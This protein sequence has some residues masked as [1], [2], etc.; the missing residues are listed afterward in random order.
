MQYAV[1]HRCSAFDF[2]NVD[3]GSIARIT[4]AVCRSDGSNRARR[5]THHASLATPPGTSD[6]RG[7]AGKNVYPIQPS[8]RAS[9]KPRVA[10]RAAGTNAWKMEASVPS[11]L[12]VDNDIVILRVY[13]GYSPEARP[14]ISQPLLTEDDHL[15]S[16]KNL[17]WV[18]DMLSLPRT[19]PGLLAGLTL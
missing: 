4:A 10:N 18:D 6:C 15:F 12:D 3:D 14:I 5:R 8:L 19:R 7:S 13:G 9:G 16:L 17:S 2:S 11:R 1:W